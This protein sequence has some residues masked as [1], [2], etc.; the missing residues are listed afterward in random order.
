MTADVDE[1]AERP[2]AVADEHDRDVAR[3]R[4]GVNEPGSATS[5]VCPAYCQVR[6]KIVS[7]S[8]RATA[9]STYQSQGIERLPAVVAIRRDATRHQ[10]PTNDPSHTT[11]DSRVSPSMIRLYDYPA[12]ANCFKVR[13]LLPQLGLRT[14]AFPSTSSPVSHR[15]R[16]PR[17]EPRRP[18]PLLETGDGAAVPESG[19]ILLFLAEGSPFLLDDHVGARARARVDVLRAEPARAERRHGPLLEADRARRRAAERRSSATSRR[20]RGARCARARPDR[21][22]SSSSAAATPS[23]T[24]R[25]TRTRGSPA[26][27]ATTWPRIRR[28]GA[29][30]ERVAASRGRPTTWRRT[31]RP[32]GR[33]FLEGRFTTGRAAEGVEAARLRHMHRHQAAEDREL[34]A[35][36]AGGVITSGSP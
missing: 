19:A 1:R 7:C 26:T 6:R 22:R 25:C 4:A 3:P 24:A 28:C 12:S 9:G 2:A 13:M 29:W 17:A 16:L 21:G 27:P 36:H 35:D 11:G 31:P 30:L 14:N 18:H 5:P 32:P 8:S 23:P 34:T 20:E 33:G 10:A 15:S